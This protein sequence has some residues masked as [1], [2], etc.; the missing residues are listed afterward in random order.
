MESTPIYKH[1]Y[2]PLF[3]HLHLLIFQVNRT[4]ICSWRFG[5]L[6][7]DKGRIVFYRLYN[8]CIVFLLFT[9]WLRKMRPYKKRI[10]FFGLSFL[11]RY[12]WS[13]RNRNL[14]GLYANIAEAGSIESSLRIFLRHTAGFFK[15]FPTKKK[16]FVAL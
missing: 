4:F 2:L 10:C 15:F 6:F 11:W 12:F 14:F 13:L 9:C 5:L 3:T 8:L 1:I 16:F 7:K